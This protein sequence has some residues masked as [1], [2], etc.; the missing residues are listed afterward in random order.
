MKIAYV[1]A[2]L[3]GCALGISGAMALHVA[4]P[5]PDAGDWL[6]FAGALTG[7][8]LTISGTLWLEDYRAKKGER[9][10]IEIYRNAV[11]EIQRK[12]DESARERGE[13]A[14]ETFRQDQI[15]REQN[16]ARS[17]EK[18][19][20]ARHYVPRRNIEAWQ[21][22]EELAK[23][24]ADEKLG[25]EHEARLISDAGENENV[26]GVNLGKMAE[27]RGRLDQYL[28]SSLKTLDK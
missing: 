7:V 10:G 16:L 18:F 27:L 17:F 1:V 8:V 14:I 9:D 21:A 25:V 28:E 3:V 4:R 26:L 13:E 2:L 11:G 20:Y 19:V 6:A 15:Q 5:G 24:V 12:L 22:A 23:R